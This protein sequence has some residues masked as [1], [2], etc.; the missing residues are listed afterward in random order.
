MIKF[1]CFWRQLIK[2]SNAH[3]FSRRPTRLELLHTP[4]YIS[5]NEVSKYPQSL[6]TFIFLSGTWILI[7]VLKVTDRKLAITLC[8]NGSGVL[9][10]VLSWTILIRRRIHKPS[11]KMSFHWVWLHERVVNVCW[12]RRLYAGGYIIRQFVL[13]H[14]QKTHFYLTVNASSYVYA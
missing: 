7:L 6:T 3:G 2:I 4:K 14:A 8:A 5:T 10:E 13:S 12:T 11:I 9:F 1:I